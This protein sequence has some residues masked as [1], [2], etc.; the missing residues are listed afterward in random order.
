VGRAN[1]IR[2]LARG[3][4][5]V[6]R[7]D[8][9]IHEQAAAGGG[10]GAVDRDADRRRRPVLVRALEL[11]VSEIAL[12]AGRRQPDDDALP[13]D[14]VAAPQ[15]LRLAAVD[16][17]DVEER[18]LARPALRLVIVAPGE[19]YPQH[20]NP[21]RVLA[22]PATPGLGGALD[23]VDG[24]HRNRRGGDARAVAAHDGHRRHHPSSDHDAA[25]AGIG[26]PAR[27]QRRQAVDVRD[28]VRRHHDAGGTGVHHHGVAA[29]AERDAQARRLREV[30]AGSGRVEIS[31][32]SALL[33]SAIG[34][35]RGGGRRQGAEREPRNGRHCRCK[36]PDR[37]AISA[38]PAGPPATGRRRSA[39]S[40]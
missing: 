19:A 15:P 40:M 35:R 12:R 36:G 30:A 3:H 16:G 8:A 37:H 28:L 32:E 23:P 5:Q 1:R 26:E 17:R 31:E 33:V 21:A 6:H 7:G 20:R 27:P 22:R 24:Q 29:R 13:G 14:E 39:R 2:R 38:T 34:A 11:D 10:R 9:G 25:G 18:V 4:R